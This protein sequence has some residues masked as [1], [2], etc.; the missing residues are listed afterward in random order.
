MT[1]Y[2]ELK[3]SVLYIMVG[4]RTFAGLLK[5]PPGVYESS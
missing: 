3:F 5:I 4:S 2:D 1:I